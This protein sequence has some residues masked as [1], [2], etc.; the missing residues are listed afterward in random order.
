MENAYFICHSVQVGASD[1]FYIYR[2]QNVQMY[3]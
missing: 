2:L 1:L 3:I